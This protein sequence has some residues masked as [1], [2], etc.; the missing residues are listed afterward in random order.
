MKILCSLSACFSRSVQHQ[1]EQGRESEGTFRVFT[2]SELK[3]ATQR[4]DSSNKIGEGGFGTVYKGRLLDGTFVA[5]KVLSIELDSL[6]GEKEFVAELGT[7]GD[8]K[9]ENLVTLR[10]CCVEGAHRYLVY[11]YM[12]NNSLHHYFLGSQ[13]GRMRFNWES[14]RDICIG[15]ARGLAYLHEEIRPYIVHRDIKARNILLD[16]RLRPKLS[17]FGL[18]KL[19]RD[20]KSYVSTQVAGTLGYLAPEYASSGK[21]TRKSDVYSYGVLVL[22]IVSGL[23]VVDPYQDTERFL[24]EKA[25][26]AYEGGDV[27][28][29][30]DAELKERWPEEEGAR[31]LKVGLLCVQETAKLRPR[32]TQVVEMLSNKIDMA[33]VSI[34]KPGV[35]ADLRAIRIREPSHSSEV[36]SSGAATFATSIWSSSNLAR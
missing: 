16:R 21:V 28:K 31:F 2:Y 23:P 24:V 14:R 32:M 12:E 27:A 18:A 33:S 30:V 7:L 10:G 35:V 34:S 19:L 13:E 36:S 15:V 1:T 26:S 6:Q 5:V 22:E 4:F 9:H 29:M 11:E 8:I 25:W 17:D 3:S 20:D